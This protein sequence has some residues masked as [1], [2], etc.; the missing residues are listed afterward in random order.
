MTKSKNVLLLGAAALALAMA[1]PPTFA[2]EQ[3]P[4]GP[5][6]IPTP[7]AGDCPPEAGEVYC[8]FV[9]PP[10]GRLPQIPVIVITHPGNLFP[11]NQLPRPPS[12]SG[13]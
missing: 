8:P 1:S 2:A 9:I 10:P 3:T 11:H 13:H 12:S 7:D 6:R 4:P 5:P